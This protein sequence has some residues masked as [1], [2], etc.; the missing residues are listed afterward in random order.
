MLGPS[1][2][3]QKDK[4]FVDTVVVGMSGEICLMIHKENGLK[5][6]F[7]TV[8]LHTPL[9]SW[10]HFGT[11]TPPSSG[12]LV[13]RNFRLSHAPAI[14]SSQE[15]GNGHLVIIDAFLNVK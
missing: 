4:I 5:A 2:I 10:D 1:M 14:F 9:K 15:A 6:T 13:V 7:R 8:G 12:T 3:M 11:H